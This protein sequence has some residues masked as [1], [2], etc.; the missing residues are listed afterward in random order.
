LKQA[1]MPCLLLLFVLFFIH[2]FDAAASLFE[3]QLDRVE[4]RNALERF[5]T[6]ERSF[7]QRGLDNSKTYLP[8]VK[9]ALEKEDLPPALAWLP[10]IESAYSVR[11]YSR[12]GACGIWQFMPQ[13]GKWYNLR[14]DFWVDERRDPFKSSASAARHIGDLY[15]YY[16]NWEL[17]LAAYNAG[18][19]SVNRAIRYGGTR[20]YWELCRRKL[21]KRETRQYVPRFYAVCEIAEHPGMYGF[22]IKE[23]GG[24]PDFE[25]LTTDRPVDLNE[26]AARSTIDGETI[27]LLN[28]ELRRSLTPIGRK[29]RLRIPAE[30]FA[31]VLTVYHELPEGQLAGV[32]PYRVKSGET[33]SEIAE[34]FDVSLHLITLLNN[35]YDPRRLF[36]GRIILVPFPEGVEVAIEEETFLP[37]WG[38]NTQQI[39]YRIRRGDTLWEIATRYGTDVETIL[40][41]NGLSYESMIRPGDEIAIWVETAFC[42]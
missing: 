22:G 11:A 2:P 37:K 28:P 6:C 23:G 30:R 5:L 34:R 3:K 19:G 33:V 18:M 39:S 21:L 41:I 24:F 42:R 13:T 29:Y 8:I 12:T 31:E 4:V 27:V 35:I 10:L 26:L 40:A 15:R 38:F 9:A 7:V 36:A 17:A 32:S 20:N 1:G 25:I 16:R 14:I